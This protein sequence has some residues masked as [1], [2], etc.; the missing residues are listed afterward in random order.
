MDRPSWEQTVRRN[1]SLVIGIALGAA[2]GVA[3]DNLGAGMALG[4]A[5]GIALDHRQRKRDQ[6]DMNS[7]KR[8]SD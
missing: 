2:F 4:I 1:R 3:L 5:L 8:E 6:K 7:G